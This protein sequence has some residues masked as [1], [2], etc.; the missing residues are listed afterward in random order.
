MTLTDPQLNL[1]DCAG[2]QLGHPNPDVAVLAGVTLRVLDAV[3]N[4]GGQPIPV[5]QL[6]AALNPAAVRKTIGR[7][8]VATSRERFREFMSRLGVNW[9]VRTHKSG[10][11]FIEIPLDKLIAASPEEWAREDKAA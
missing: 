2:R 1:I 11:K 6:I 5:P 3:A 4:S 7:G 8:E 9:R 10:R